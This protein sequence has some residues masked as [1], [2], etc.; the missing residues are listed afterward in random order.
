M[1]H[2]DVVPK[3]MV[4]VWC[5]VVAYR[6]PAE[7]I[8]RLAATLA[9]TR[10]SVALTIV[11][12]AGTLPHALRL[13]GMMA[14]ERLSP[15]RNLG[16]GRAHNL[17]IAQS[18]DRCRYHLVLNSDIE[19]DA[20]VIDAL[21]DFMDARPTAGLVMPM[22]RYPDGE[23]QYLCRLLPNPVTLIGRRFFG[24]T[25][26]ARRL[27][28]R[29]ELHDWTYNKVASFPFLSG[30]FMFI[31]RTT[32][33]KVEGFDP[34]FFLYAEDLDLSRRLHMVSE[35][36]FYPGVSITHE[37]RSLKRRSWRQWVYALTSLSQYFN[38]WGWILDAERDRINQRT[39]A[40]IRDKK[41]GA[42]DKESIHQN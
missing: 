25:Q 18:R 33:D 34:R 28:D 4:D 15:G 17:A 6:T 12:N 41:Q 30:C 31:R 40:K 14:I 42:E 8:E 11:D 3:G 38:K 2:K 23:L 7:E 24:G 35:T 5:S 16:Y 29:Y 26:W 36:L 13:P 10:V 21:V 22:V 1:T 19:F 37:Y 39:V 9:H 27:N 32:L 20:S